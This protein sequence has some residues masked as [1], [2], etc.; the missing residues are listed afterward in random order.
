[1]VKLSEYLD[2]IIPRGSNQLVQ[3]I[4]E[5]AQVPVMGHADGI[6][7]VF[8]DQDADFEKAEQIVLDSKTD[9]PAVCNAAET[10]LI[11]QNFPLERTVKIL[12]ELQRKDVELRV[13]P[14]L[15]EALKPFADLNLSSAEEADC[16]TEYT[17][18]IL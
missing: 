18:L 6:C 17:Y 14:L 1:M 15:K 9:Y 16:S 11:H 2:L 3:Y 12:R 13:C 8:L 10:L 5:N 4:Q 7:H